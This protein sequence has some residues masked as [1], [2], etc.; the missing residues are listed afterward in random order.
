MGVGDIA[1]DSQIKAATG[2]NL[3]KFE[4]QIISVQDQATK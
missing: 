2:I 4:N 3:K 1:S